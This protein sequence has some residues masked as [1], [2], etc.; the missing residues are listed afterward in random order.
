MIAFEDALRTVLSAS[1]PLPAARLP[2]GRCLGRVLAGPVRT[3]VPLP[4]FTASAVDGYAVRAADIIVPGGP[5]PVK[6]PL[7]GVV[8][9][10]EPSPPALRRGCAVR[11]LT[12]APLPAGA[13]TV[14]MQE[15][16]LLHDGGV[17][18]LRPDAEGANVRRAGEEFRRGDTILTAGSIVT[19][20]VLSLLATAGVAAVRVHRQPRVAVLVTGDELV[21]AG[22]TPSPG[23]I[24]DAN[25]PGLVGA[26]A[27]MGVR[28]VLTMRRRDSAPAIREALRRSLHAAD[29]VLTSGGV[30]EGT[31]DHV[32]Q[33]CTALGVRTLFWKSAIKPGKPLF[34]GAKGKRLV[35]GLPGNPV[36]AMVCF[37]LFVRPAL[38]RMM[39]AGEAHVPAAR[40]SLAADVVK[41]PGRTEFLRGVLSRDEG[42]TLVVTPVRGQDSHMVGG[43]AAADVL[44]VIPAAAGRVAAGGQ[45]DVVPLHWSIL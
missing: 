27:A 1:S 3:A 40:A 42:G 15:H 25:T 20:P 23:R 41:K 2:V 33:A 10:G 44:A 9:A 35:L 26:L 31:T 8:K 29:M 45:V 21:A 13:D 11:I 19:P 34:A 4:R 18:I 39:G 5:H 28:P 16:T 36:S 24:P 7:Q 37:H 14:V 12:G 17:E 32:K 6:L 43:L 30:S 22:R 38:L